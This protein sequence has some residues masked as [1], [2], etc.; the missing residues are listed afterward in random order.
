MKRTA[1]FTAKKFDWDGHYDPNTVDNYAYLNPKA[2][3]DIFT[4]T[5][6]NSSKADCEGYL[7][8]RNGK[9]K[10]YL[11]YKGCNVVNKGDVMLSYQNLSFLKAV[12]IKG[13]TKASIEISPSCYF[14]FKFMNQN[15]EIRWA[16]IISLF[17]IVLSCVSIICTFLK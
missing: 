14:A 8:L 5:K 4:N 12:P 6:S 2:F 17:S 13:E 15:S 10:I 3:I 16:F 11:K 9:R 7:K 1:T